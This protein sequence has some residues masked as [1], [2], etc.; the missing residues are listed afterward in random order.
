MH[1][2]RRKKEKK[3]G[4]LKLVKNVKNLD[5]VGSHNTSSFL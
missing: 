3:R 4:A 2:T 1:E 5:S